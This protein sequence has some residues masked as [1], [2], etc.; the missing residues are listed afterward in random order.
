M[1]KLSVLLIITFLVCML[2]IHQIRMRMLL[3]YFGIAVILF[4]KRHRKTGLLCVFF[5]CGILVSHYYLFNI[6]LDKLRLQLFKSFYANEAKA[7]LKEEEKSINE[8]VSHKIDKRGS[9]AFLTQDRSYHVYRDD[10]N[11]SVYL[12]TLVSFF[13]SYGYVYSED[14]LD[15]ASVNSILAIKNY[16]YLDILDEHWVYIKVY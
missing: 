8:L 2:S 6:N 1:K 15:A 9:C 3:F 4:I 5:C 13:S 7:I 16:D 14:K 10:E 12:P 11:I